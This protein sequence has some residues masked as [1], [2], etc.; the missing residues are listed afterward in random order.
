MFHD[1]RVA[2]KLHAKAKGQATLAAVRLIDRSRGQVNL[3]A[4]TRRLMDEHFVKNLQNQ[5]M[6]CI[7]RDLLS[8]ASLEG[9][10]SEPATKRPRID[11]QTPGGGLAHGDIDCEDAPCSD[12]VCFQLALIN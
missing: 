12:R 4:V 2:G 11:R 8:L 5:G 3:D 6:Y 9:K 1:F 10:L 7:R